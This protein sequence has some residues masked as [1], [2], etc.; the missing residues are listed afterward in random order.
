[1]PALSDDRVKL[2]WVRVQELPLHAGTTFLKEYHKIRRPTEAMLLGT[3]CLF[4]FPIDHYLPLRVSKLSGMV[5][6]RGDVYYGVYTLSRWFE[7]SQKLWKLKIWKGLKDVAVKE[8]FLH[9]ILPFLLREPS[10]DTIFTDVYCQN[11]AISGGFLL[12]FAGYYIQY[13]P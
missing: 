10:C 12:C 5:C 3:L 1:M 4:I 13:P 8:G 11:L 9:S 2:T 6:T 7:G